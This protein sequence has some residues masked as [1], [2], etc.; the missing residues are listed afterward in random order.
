MALPII[1]AVLRLPLWFTLA[2]LLIGTVLLFFSPHL[3]EK[4]VRDP[5][6]AW[7]QLMATFARIQSAHAALQDSPADAAAR[8]RFA[9]LE[10]ECLSLLNSRPDS[11]WGTDA[12]Y[13]EKIRKE[14]SEMSAPVPDKVEGPA[15]APS[16]ETGRLEELRKQ[17][18]MFDSEFQAFSER[19]KTL[20]T[21]KACAAL[22]TI[23][24]FQ[25]KCRQGAVTQVDFHVAMRGLLERLDHEDG[26]AAPQPVTTAQ[27]GQGAAGG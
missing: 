12:G 2:L 5:K 13:V 19:F 14:I 27:S 18:V 21:E 10:A 3:A 7:L 11:D 15:P 26:E 23:A 1:S 16:P 6:K 22:E 8:M 9:K 20:A 17:G 4:R 25:L 24:G